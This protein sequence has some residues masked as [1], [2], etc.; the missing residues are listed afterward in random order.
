MT[1][2][3]ELSLE[4]IREIKNE[5]LL[6]GAFGDYFCQV[7]AFIDF[8]IEHISEKPAQTLEE[9][10]ALNKKLYEEVL[11]V[12][13]EKSFL[14]P[15]WAVSQLGDGYGQLLSFLYFQ[16][17]GL[18]PF[19]YELKSDGRRYEDIVILLE[20]FLEVYSAFVC[21]AQENNVPAAETLKDI[22]YYFISDYAEVTVRERVRE[23][24]DPSLS[25]A[26]DIIKTAELSD[27]SYLYDF[28]EYITDNEIKTAEHLKA[29][30][31]EQIQAMA[32]TYTEGYRIGFV[33]TG[34]DL[35]K[36]K[37]VNI[38]YVLGFERIVRAAIKNFEKMGLSCIIYRSGTHLL[39][40]SSASRVGFYGAIANRQYDYD[41]K[42][43]LALFWDKALK[44]RRLDIL[45]SA[46]E[47]FKTLANTHAGPAV[48]ETFGE[49]PF[50]PVSKALVPHH[51]EKQQR[52]L[53]EYTSKAGA[54]V[55]EYI[56][57]EERSFTII[58]YPIPEI[59]SDYD[60][61][62]DETVK[63]NTLDYK[64]YQTMQQHIIDE[65]DQGSAAFIRGAGDNETE[66]TVGLRTLSNPDKETQFE[67][68][69]ADVN[70]P[71]GEVFTSPV[72]EGTNGLLHVKRVYLNGLRFENLKLTFTDGFVTDYSCSNFE[73][74]D[75]N[76]KYIRD[77]VLFKHDTLPMGEFAIGTNTTAY[78]MAKRFDIFD[79]L[80]I[81]IAEKTGPHFAVGDTCYSHAEEVK[82]YNPDGKEII[83]RENSCSLKRDSE[84]DK[85]YFNCHTDVTIPYEELLEIGIIKNNGEKTYIIKDGRFVVSGTEALNEPLT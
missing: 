60:K 33:M 81:L 29:M 84:P 40:G 21:E 69:V 8:A 78:A 39:S 77:N 79:R 11:P 58:A 5:E 73:S 43:D 30:S 68:C 45:K 80:P 27:I 26:A 52:L 18:I 46:Y 63:L 7:A 42:E 14:N 36:K 67:N 25:F 31:E 17:R 23:I 75:E 59:G 44:D 65:L 66:L 76:K 16:I 1:E 72:L 28:G 53:V 70:I 51:D 54:L 38:R 3:Y 34:K 61:I 9:K 15:E 62:F 82:V 35:S 48:M 12:N 20:V 55:N 83:S 37:T 71:V 57:G 4:R 6:K 19:L 41:H 13:Y 50:S 49:V 74:E 22:L 64:T 24:V 56:K 47:E 10:A 2:R 85:A 32:D